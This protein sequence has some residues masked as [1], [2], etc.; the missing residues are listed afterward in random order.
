MCA[1]QSTGVIAGCG[2]PPGPTIQALLIA[3]P[4]TLTAPT[5]LLDKKWGES[6]KINKEMAENRR[7]SAAGISAARLTG[8]LA[9]IALGPAPPAR[10]DC[11]SPLAR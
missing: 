3:G 10:A 1:E 2:D 4:N 11:L 5:H 7:R 9:L 8:E 6:N